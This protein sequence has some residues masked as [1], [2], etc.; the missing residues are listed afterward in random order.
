MINRLLYFLA[1]FVFVTFVTLWQIKDRTLSQ[2]PAQWLAAT[3]LPKNTRLSSNLVYRPAF[4]TPFSAIPLPELAAI[5]GMYLTADILKDQPINAAEL[6]LS[7]FFTPSELNELVMVQADSATGQVVRVN[8][9]ATAVLFTNNNGPGIGPFPVLATLVE[10]S[11]FLTAVKVTDPVLRDTLR[12]SG[13]VLL[14]LA[15]PGPAENQNP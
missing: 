10:G 6:R 11:Q 13:S 7:P 12:K 3:F 15:T 4:R 14:R 9:G 2:P 1:F 5:E 8:A